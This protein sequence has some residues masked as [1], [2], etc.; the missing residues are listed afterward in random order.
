M[1]ELLSPFTGIIERKIQP[2][3]TAIE[4]IPDQAE[5]LTKMDPTRALDQMHTRI[6][7]AL[8]G[9]VPLPIRKAPRIDRWLRPPGA[10]EP[11]EF[12]SVCSRCGQCVEA[13]PAEAIHLDPNGL[14]ADGFPY[15]VPADQPCVVCEDL[16][17]MKSCPTGALQLVDRLAIDLGTAKVDHDLCLRDRGENCTL[18]LDVCPVMD[19]EPARCALVA[20]PLTGKIIVHKNICIG[21]GLCENRCPTEPR[22]ITILP[23]A[24]PFD[25]MIA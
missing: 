5:R 22:A 21:C 18:C 13:C 14:I 16:A 2:I 3:L 15:I 8:P 4:S 11:G 25:P 6:A 20:S 12:E 10:M 23:H 1:R 24:P 17:C 7:K 9:N 19:E